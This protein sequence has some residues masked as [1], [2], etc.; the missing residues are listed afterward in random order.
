[1]KI[2]DRQTLRMKPRIC[3]EMHVIGMSMTLGIGKMLD[4]QITSDFLRRH[5]SRKMHSVAQFFVFLYPFTP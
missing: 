2:T 5:S 3:V 4:I 1:M